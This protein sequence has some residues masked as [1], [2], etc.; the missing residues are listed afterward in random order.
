MHRLL[1]KW[2]HLLRGACAISESASRDGLVRMPPFARIRANVDAEFKAM[3]GSWMKRLFCSER[4]IPISQDLMA[5]MERRMISL[6]GRHAYLT[7]ALSKPAASPDEIAT[8]NK[9]LSKMEDCIHT[10]AALRAKREEM[11]GLKSI[12]DDAV[13][14]EEMHKLA[15]DEFRLASSDELELQHQVLFMML[16]RDEADRRGCILE[17]RA[18]TGGEEASLFAMDIFKMYERFAQKQSWRFE[19]LDVTETDL[20]GYKEASASITGDGVYGKLKFESGVHRV[21]R[22]PVTEKQGRVHTSAAS[23]A[24]LPQ[25]DELDVQLRPEDLRIDTYRAGGAGG[26]HTNTTNSAV[27]ITH[28]PTGTVVAIQDERSQHQNKAKALKVLRAKI[29]E[30]ERLR[31]QSMRSNLRQEQ[32]HDRTFIHQDC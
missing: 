4:R 12:L 31:Q 30:K 3:F 5:V 15:I 1:P 25:A 28:I 27:R 8:I 7:Q 23:V 6:E 22:V 17:V 14:D 32:G 29:Y 9:E 26:Q 18:G 11:K 13:E 20:R 16:P 21:Q 2:S 24:V 10:I 19:V